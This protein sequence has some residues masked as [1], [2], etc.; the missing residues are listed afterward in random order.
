MC[1]KSRTLENIGDVQ[2]RKKRLKT[3]IVV[4]KCFREKKSVCSHRHSLQK[5][6]VTVCEFFCKALRL[7]Q[8]LFFSWKQ[9][10]K[11]SCLRLF[12]RNWTS[13]FL[14]GNYWLQFCGSLQQVN[15]KPAKVALPFLKQREPIFSAFLS[16]DPFWRC[17]GHILT[18]IMEK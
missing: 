18:R 13:S 11:K 4:W 2:L 8:T 6:A 12:L 10:Q 17:R 3:K 16:W 7:L 5:N 1:F 14:P 15:E 9:F